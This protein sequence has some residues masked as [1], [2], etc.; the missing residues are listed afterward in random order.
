MTILVACIGEDQK[1]WGHVA[2]LIKDMEWEHVYLI[3]AEAG[4]SFQCDKSAE[5]MIVD[6]KKPVRDLISDIITALQGKIS[7]KE[8][9]LNLV[10]GSG[11][12]HMAILSA[13]LKLGAGIRLIAVTKDGVEEI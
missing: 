6:T 10:S 5:Y 2:R 7:F 1:S 4:K 11:K 12:E 8:V 13:L 9:A 3:M